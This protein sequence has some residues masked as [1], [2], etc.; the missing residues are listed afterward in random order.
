M[1][2]ST[3]GKPVRPSRHA[4]KPSRS[5]VQRRLRLPAVQDAVV[6]AEHRHHA[7]VGLERRVQ[8]GVVVDPEVARV[9]DERGQPACSADPREPR[10]KCA[11]A[12]ATSS[13]T[14]SGWTMPALTSDAMPWTV[15]NKTSPTRSGSPGSSAPSP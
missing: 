13:S 9:P 7:I 10:R 3:R 8:R 1:P 14:C 2:A 11:T 12:S 6:E 15:A 5:P 4:S